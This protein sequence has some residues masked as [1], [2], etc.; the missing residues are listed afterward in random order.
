MLN[1]KGMTEPTQVSKIPFFFVVGR[2]RS[3]TTLLRCIFDAHPQ[4]VF[5]LECAFMIHLRSKYGKIQIWDEKHLTA[6]YNDLLTYPK[7][8]LWT[9]DHEKLLS[10][11]LLLKGKQSYSTICKT[12]YYNFSSLF[13]KDEIRLLGD[14]NPS[15][16]LYI[17]PLISLFPEARFIHITRDYRD[18]IISMIRARFETKIYS[19]LAYRWKFVNRQIIRQ[20]NRFPERFYT[21]RYEDMVSNPGLYLKQICAF[22]GI[23]FSPAMLDY[24]EKL[25]ELLAIYPLD[26]INLHHKSLLKPINADKLNEWKQV[27]TPKEIKICDTVMGNFAEENGYERMYK[28]RNFFVYLSCLPGMF[29]GRL[30]FFFMRLIHKMPLGVQMKIINLLASIFKHDW[31]RF[32]KKQ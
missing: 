9:I 2:A 19:S 23:D 12:V 4:I 17:K 29:Y 21:L 22:L 28:K 7:F 10:D 15:Y 3:G 27:L 31:K 11:L 6:F 1:D 13:P 20:K 18:N 16:S 25:D 24:R 14:K 8:H 32:K 5:P 26:L 30:L